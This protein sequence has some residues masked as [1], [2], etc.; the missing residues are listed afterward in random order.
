M[1]PAAPTTLATPRVMVRR[2]D[3]D[4]AEMMRRRRESCR[5]FE[6]I[7]GGSTAD[8]VSERPA[9]ESTPSW[10][11]APVPSPTP[12]CTHD[13]QAKIERRAWR[14]SVCGDVALKAR[15]SVGGKS[16][17]ELR[18]W[19]MKMREQ[20][21]VTESNPEPTTAD[22]IC[23]L[24]AVSDEP[25]WSS[26]NDCQAPSLAVA[27]VGVDR[28][29][30]EDEEEEDKEEGIASSPIV[31][32]SAEASS[33]EPLQPAERYTTWVSRL[34]RAD[35]QGE[36]AD[37]RGESVRTSI[38]TTSTEPSHETVLPIIIKLLSSEAT[39]RR[40]DG[41]VSVESL[42]NAFCRRC[43]GFDDVLGNNQDYA[44]FC[45]LA[46]L[47]RYHVPD[48]ACALDEVALQSATA[49]HLP[50]DVVSGAQVPPVARVGRDLPSTLQ[51]I[52]SNGDSCSGA[53]GSIVTAFSAS[54]SSAAPEA[55]AALLF[56]F[57]LLVAFEDRAAL[58]LFVFVALFSEAVEDTANGSA[59][60]VG[61]FCDSLFHFGSRDVNGIRRCV[62]LALELQEATPASLC[63][64]SAALSVLP[65]GSVSAEEVLR[66][67]YE[68]PASSWRLVI[69]DVREATIHQALP[70]CIRIG[71][72]RNRK[73]VAEG[74]PEENSIHLCLLADRDPALAKHS[75]DDAALMLALY[76]TRDLP[77]SR[78]KR[79]VSVVAGG[80]HAVYAAASTLGCELSEVETVENGSVKVAKVGGA[81]LKKARA[82]VMK[83]QKVLSDAGNVLERIGRNSI[84]ENIAAAAAGLNLPQ[85][86]E[87]GDNRAGAAGGGYPS[88]SVADA[89]PDIR[90]L[91]FEG[92]RRLYH[93]EFGEGTLGFA[94]SGLEVVVLDPEGQATSLGVRL[95]SRLV[96]VGGRR[97]PEPP[98]EDT[99]EEA[100]QRVRRLVKKWIK[101]KPRPILLTFAE[102]PKT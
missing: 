98:P 75:T 41:G 54:A 35:G 19:M 69:I 72:D 6:S 102:L 9:Q 60:L 38:T 51:Q 28:E 34:I 68:K 30:E 10:S 46:R 89:L 94:L 83:T 64:G 82:A 14:P 22:V 76:L 84:A 86:R 92:G 80:W 90:S 47:L 77:S 79:H 73:A 36:T 44:V 21:C 66:H 87:R 97:L 12:T 42:A 53:G 70:I 2:G 52:M 31:F 93:M 57:D 96:A 56:L 101:E 32:S 67:V 100:E 95:G 58:L 59:P 27:D 91:E 7:P 15:R 88:R 37:C 1:V 25:K 39:M 17:A 11:D 16:D 20:C 45:I 63:R 50:E 71:V 48:A 23:D 61:R 49:E 65:I 85:P 29:Q 26:G 78:R 43:I 13:G 62:R 3:S 8:A 4:L 24:P 18:K 5:E 55:S 40:G 33:W 99:P 81:V 74:L